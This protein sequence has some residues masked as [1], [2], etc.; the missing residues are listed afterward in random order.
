MT[1]EQLRAKRNEAAAK[2]KAIADIEAAGTA[3]SEEQAAEFEAASQ[4]F[5]QLDAQV[6]RADRTNGVQRRL[7]EPRPSPGAA[8]VIGNLA[9]G[10]V[11]PGG[12]EASRDFESMGEFLH[13]V[14]FNPNDQRLQFQEPTVRGEQSMGDGSAGGFMVPKQFVNS[15][16]E[17]SPQD[18][19]I[20]PRAEVIAAGSPPDAEIS[21]PGL[22]Q[23]G[24]TPDNVYGGVSVDWIGEGAE[25]TPS[26]AA[27]KEISWKPHE[28]AGNITVSN[29]LLRNWQ[30]AGAFLER[31]LR[32]ATIASEDREFLRGNGVA[33]PRGIITSGAS[34]V[35]SRTT[36]NLVKLADLH[37]MVERC[38]GPGQEW[39]AAR[40]LLSQ[41][42]A[43]QDNSGGAGI[44]GYIWQPSARDGEPDRLFGRP[45]NWHQRSPGL[46][47]KGDLV[48]ASL[49]HYVIKDGSGPFVSMSEHV[50]F[51]ANKTV[52]KITWNVDGAPWL[53]NPFK[54]E[55]GY[56]TSPF[57]V[58]DEPES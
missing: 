28:V 23:D 19:I 16:R 33:R 56:E 54:G 13:A 35:V 29:K 7:D 51:K 53:K 20:R 58:L 38:M 44:G 3:L 9:D 34:Y 27:F 10:N 50:H 15:M 43:L 18:A 31:Q 11:R 24:D 55:D 47:S 26:D 14:R 12:P 41:F 57:V 21:M 1:V 49:S 45:I 48:L 2:M 25:P 36:A 8:Q 37:A 6:R 22:D 46:G 5:E 32:G 4:G 39:I 52:I 40:A 42:L 30:A 17:V